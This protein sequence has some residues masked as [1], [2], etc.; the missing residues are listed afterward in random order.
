[1]EDQ[2]GDGRKDDLIPDASKFIDSDLIIQHKL[3]KKLTVIF[4]NVPS[5]QHKGKSLDLLLISLSGAAIPGFGFVPTGLMIEQSNGGSVNMNVNHYTNENISTT[6]LF[7]V[8]NFA[9]TL[10]IG[11]D[12]PPSY[13]YGDIQLFPAQPSKVVVPK[14]VDAP[15]QAKFDPI[16]RKLEGSST[17]NADLFH[18]TFTKDGQKWIVFYA[19]DRDGF[20][21][22]LPPDGFA[23]RIDI[24]GEA[25]LQ[26]VA[27]KQEQ[28][29]ESIISHNSLNI[30]RLISVINGFSKVSVY[31]K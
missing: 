6:S 27:L 7:A 22:P 3:D 1:V 12:P 24:D 2:N 17:P 15:T 8:M 20:E 23:D 13:I 28:T 18:F 5:V 4:S 21:L 10:P 14:F 11:E 25:S 31:T 19:G 26:A 30:D 9:L 16:T 29:L